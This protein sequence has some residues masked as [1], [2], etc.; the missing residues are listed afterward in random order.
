MILGWR[1]AGQ[2]RML[3]RADKMTL[4]RRFRC[5]A[6]LGHRESFGVRGP[7]QNLTGRATLY[8]TAVGGEAGALKAIPILKT[9][10]AER[11]D[12]KHDRSVNVSKIKG[13]VL[14]AILL[15]VSALVVAGLLVCAEESAISMVAELDGDDDS[16]WNTLNAH[17]LAEQFATDAI[18]LPPTSPTG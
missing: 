17:T 5:V 18:V 11:S 2:R 9:R 16:A 7:R 15:F 10:S 13:T 6:R 3:A 12:R 1:Y 4:I 14:K 8:G